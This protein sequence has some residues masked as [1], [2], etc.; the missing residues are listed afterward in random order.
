MQPARIDKAKSAQS[1]GYNQPFDQLGLL[2]NVSF[3]NK[4]D[5]EHLQRMQ[6]EL[7]VFTILL[8]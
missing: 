2:R 7:K 3:V 8:L 4:Q 5:N 6:K 1:A